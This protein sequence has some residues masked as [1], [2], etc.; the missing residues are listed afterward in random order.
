VPTDLLE[1][2]QFWSA[3]VNC[4]VDYAFLSCWFLSENAADKLVPIWT[5]AMRYLYHDQL[6]ERE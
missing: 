4:G 5:P 3:F 1:R 6:K 2:W